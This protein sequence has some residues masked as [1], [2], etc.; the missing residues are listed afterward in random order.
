VLSQP[1]GADLAHEV[2]TI[3][4]TFGEGLIV[5]PPSQGLGPSRP[6]CNL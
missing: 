5:A 3:L 4:Y 6:A 2:L 1:P